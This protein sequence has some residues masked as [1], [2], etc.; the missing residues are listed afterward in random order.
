MG[1]GAGM[2]VGELAWACALVLFVISCAVPWVVTIVMV[3]VIS[4]VLPVSMCAFVLFVMVG[5]GGAC[6]GVGLSV[7]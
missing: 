3:R 4:G 7:G 6:G 2:G 1:G 5:N